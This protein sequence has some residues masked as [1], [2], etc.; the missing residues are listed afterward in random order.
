MATDPSETDCDRL[1]RVPF[2]RNAIPT[3]GECCQFKDATVQS[4]LVI[5]CDDAGRITFL[6]YDGYGREF[7]LSGDLSPFAQLTE[8][9]AL[10]VPNNAFYGPLPSFKTWKKLKSLYYT[11]FIPFYLSFH[12]NSCYREVSYNVNL[13]G[14]FPDFTDSMDAIL[15]DGLR[16]N[17]PL[18]LTLPEKLTI[19]SARDCSF[20][21]AIPTQFGKLPSLSKLD[22][23]TNQLSGPIPSELAELRS[24][25]AL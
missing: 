9:T 3:G 4:T 1:L 14:A 20:F 17:Q 6:Q 21:G 16:F 5:Q 13:T 2:L 8:L 11:R 12:N 23:S 15:V 25:G 19:L 7:K 22:I 24:L 10:N 18:P